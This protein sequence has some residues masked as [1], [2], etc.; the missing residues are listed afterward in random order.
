MSTLLITGASGYL[1]RALIPL[2]AQRARVVGCARDACRVVGPAEAL[3]L[4]V[5]DAGAVEAA[6][7][8]AQADAIVHAAASNPG[9]RSTEQMESVNAHGA[10]HVAKAA[11]RVDARLVLVSTDNVFDGMHAPYADNAAAEPLA[12]NA[13]GVSKAAGER[14]SLSQCPSAVIVRTSLIYGTREV[15]R[16]TAGFIERLEAGEPLRLFNDVLRQPMHDVVL[17]E[18]LLKLALDLQEVHGALNLASAEVLS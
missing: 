15:D 5:T 18:G 2:A 3:A 10:A 14:A 9:D 8:L 17:S 6:V 4:D 11:W 16:G 12:A 1:A 13:Y 7:E